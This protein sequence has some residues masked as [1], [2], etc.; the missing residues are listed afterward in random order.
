MIT[1]D[2]TTVTYTDNRNAPEAKRKVREQLPAEKKFDRL[3]YG[4]IS[5]AAQA[6]AGIAVSNWLKHGSGAPL[7]EKMA[8]W[9]GPKVLS[10]INRVSEKE[11]IALSDG[12]IKTT[13]M[14][15][16][17]NTFILP[18]KW[19]EDRKPEIIRK[20]TE[21]TNDKYE[22]AGVHITP[23][24]KEKQQ[25]LLEELKNEPEQTWWSLT[26]GR[27][28]ALGAVYTI[29]WAMRK[30][31]ATGKKL[32]ADTI[33]GTVKGVGL[34]SLGKSKTMHNLSGI[35]FYD[36]FYSTVSAGGLYIYSHFIDPPKNKHADDRRTWVVSNILEG[37]IQDEQPGGSLSQGWKQTANSDSKQHNKPVAATNESFADA[38]VNVKGSDNAEV[39]QL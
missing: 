29:L 39:A 4:G 24:A 31:N 25:R 27:V 20:W 14:I 28:F 38:V 9:F 26:K 17:G 12:W 3:V 16:V 36:V 15:M 37:G 11:A 10:K 1:P 13:A 21:Q 7:F 34:K 6:A 22:K 32:M 35:A 30:H 19:L 23:E 2:K 8:N 33:T 18:V 5:Y